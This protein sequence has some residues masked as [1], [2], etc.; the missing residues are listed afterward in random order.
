MYVPTSN[1]VVEVETDEDHDEV[2][3]GVDDGHGEGVHRADVLDEDGTIRRGEGLA[4]GL[5]EEVH[6]HDDSRPLEVDALEE[7]QVVALL[8]LLLQRV[9]QSGELLVDLGVRDG[10]DSEF[11]EGHLRLFDSVLGQEPS[12]GLDRS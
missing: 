1:A 12:G 10:T 5:L 9:L 2:D 4:S 7:L 11:L 6:D 3:N 8:D